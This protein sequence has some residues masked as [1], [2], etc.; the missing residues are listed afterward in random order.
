MNIVIY[1]YTH[2]FGKHVQN[3]SDVGSTHP[4][5]RLEELRVSLEKQ[6]EEDAGKAG[7]IAMFRLLQS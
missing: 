7:L 2:L 6:M 3:R 4:R 1:I 5:L